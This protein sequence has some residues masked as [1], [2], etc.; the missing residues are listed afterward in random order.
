MASNSYLDN[1]GLA[2]FLTKLAS[3]IPAWFPS[4][5]GQSGKVLTT[6]GFSL[7]WTAQAGGD[8]RLVEAWKS[9]NGGLWYRKWSDGWI[10]QGGFHP[11]TGTWPDYADNLVISFITPFANSNNTVFVA[12]ISAGDIANAYDVTTTQYTLWIGDRLQGA[13]VT[14][15]FF[16]YACGY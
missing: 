14:D 11:S 3:W 6:D 4:Q 7:S 5:T 9:S 12:M 15:L 13:S 8:V 10:E 16:W 1:S 2:Y